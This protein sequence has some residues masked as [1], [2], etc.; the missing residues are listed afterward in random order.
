MNLE[1]V[2]QKIKRLLALL[3]A[4]LLFFNL[5]IRDTAVVFAVN[6]SRK[7]DRAVYEQSDSLSYLGQTLDG[8]VYAGIVSVTSKDGQISESEKGE[9]TD[10]L[11]YTKNSVI[12]EY[13]YVLDKEKNVKKA[14][15][16]PLVFDDSV[17][18]LTITEPVD[19]EQWTTEKMIVAEAADTNLYGIYY[20]ENE[21]VMLSEMLTAIPKELK[22]L[23]GNTLYIKE[24]LSEEKVYYFYAVDKAGHVSE[25]KKAAVKKVDCQKPKIEIQSIQ[26][27]GYDK[28]RGIYWKSNEP[29][30]LSFAVTDH[31]SG[32]K[33]IKI[34][35]QE[36]TEGISENRQRADVVYEITSAGSYQ[37]TVED[38]AGN[39]VSGEVINV[40]QDTQAP[41]KIAY[42]RFI[43]D[44]KGANAEFQEEKEGSWIS[45]IFKM[46]EN[47][48][49]KIWGKR[50]VGFEVYVYDAISEI[51]SVQMSYEGIGDAKTEE[52]KKIA[53][54][55]GG[56]KKRIDGVDY[57]IF[58]GS[59]P[60]SAYETLVMKKISIDSL[61]DAA[62]NETKNIVLE[63]TE[64]NALIY[65]DSV[66]PEIVSV[67][68]QTEDGTACEEVFDEEYYDNEKRY[69]VVTLAERFFGEE[70]IPVYPKLIVNQKIS[71]EKDRTSPWE[72]AAALS[73]AVWTKAEGVEDQWFAKAELPA[74]KDTEIEYQLVIDGYQDGAGN[75]LNSRNTDENGNFTSKLLVI[76]TLAP[77]IT[78]YTEERTTECTIDGTEVLR[79]DTGTENLKVCFTLD[80]NEAYYEKSKENLTITLYRD[81]ETDPVA[82][83]KADDLNPETNGR[84]HSYSFVYDGENNTE[85]KFHAE[86]TYAD[87]AGNGLVCAENLGFMQSTEKTDTCIGKEF[88]ID[89][90]NPVLGVV[91]SEASNVV[92]SK[93]EKTKGNKEPVSGY[94]AYYN[95]DITVTLSLEEM[96]GHLGAEDGLEHF[97]FF[98]QKDGEALKE[99][100]KITWI[101]DGRK[102]TAEF[103]LE[104][105]ADH[106]NDGDYQFTVKYRD[107][108]GNLMNT[109]NVETSNEAVEKEKNSVYTSPKL[110]IDT[111]APEIT[112]SYENGDICQ[113]V[114]S[115]LG[116]FRDYLNRSCPNFVIKIKDRNIN[117]TE[118][119][120]KLENSVSVTDIHEIAIKNT[121]IK[122][123]INKI[124]EGIRCAKGNENP[125]TM[126]IVLSLATD[127]N[128]RIPVV[129]TDLAGNQAIVKGLTPEADYGTHYTEY[130]TKDSTAPKLKLSYSTDDKANYWEWGY[131][132]AKSKMT[133]TAKAE[134]E[135]S[136][137]EKI[138]FKVVD[139]NGKELVR[140][141]AFQEPTASGKYQVTI[142]L[143]TEDFKGSVYAETV[144]YAAN[145]E[146]EIRGYIVESTSKHSAT[147]KAEITTITR[148]SRTVNGVDFYN[149]DITFKILLQDTYSGIAKW[150]Y[151]GG[152]TLKYEKDYKASVGTDLNSKLT[153]KEKD[154][155][156]TVEETLRLD[157]AAN[158]EN[159]IFV[160][161]EYTDN[162]G[163]RLDVMREYNID[164]TKPVIT[165]DYDLN[166][167]ANGKYYKETRTA[168]VQIRERNFDPEDVEW[169]ITT[170]DGSLPEISGWSQSGSGDN[171]LNVCT[172]AF[173]SDSDYTFS[174]KFMD[175]AGNVAD[176]TR[177]DE[178]TIDQTEPKVTVTYDNNSCRNEYYYDAS[179]TATIDILEHNFD[180]SAIEILVTADDSTAEIPHIL[181]W[182][183]NGDHNITT[184]I[185]NYDAEYTFDI[186]GTDLAFNELADYMP[187]HFVVDQTA[188]ELEIFDIED[189]S[190]NNGEVRPGIRYHDTNYD[191]NGAVILMTGYNNGAV[192]INVTRKQETNGMELKLDDFAY[193]QEQDDLYTMKATV[194]DLAGNRSEETVMFSVNRFGSVYTYDEATAALVGENGKYYTKT[195]QALK[196][197]ETNVDTLEFKEITV[198]FN[199]KL[200]TLKE[201]QDYTV[202]ASG[203]EVTW[204]QYQYNIKADNFKEEGTYVVTIYS[205]DRAAN[206]SDNNTKGKKIAFV[207]D[208]TNPSILVSGIETN[209]QYKS[210]SQEMFIDIDD[211]VLAAKVSVIIDGAETIFDAAKIAELDGRICISV[212]AANHAQNIKIT[213]ADAAGNSSETEITNVRVNANV[214]M[215]FYLN[216]AVFYGTLCSGAVLTA[217]L[218]RFLSGKKK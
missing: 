149:E 29:I 132:F 145:T 135:I 199:G 202:K 90:V 121:K 77:K 57:Q 153:D 120:K 116:S 20:T 125:E 53:V 187:D 72:E 16:K 134:D 41:E 209:G 138:V 78:Q 85:N 73:T 119:K 61:R 203:T 36:I 47:H 34:N 15:L 214:F 65:L 194:Y 26:H 27:V 40:R 59:I 96:F 8:S 109:E 206:R 71:G 146:S 186:A 122:E 51:V 162:V 155:L 218:W 45:Q 39:K 58:Y 180:P 46:A 12:P 133:I 100:P 131:F 188:P 56:K 91:Y 208:K 103:T 126:K 49:K 13:V 178:F 172:V 197:T 3:L 185:F 156:Y 79:N 70:E 154:I 92:N 210:S 4:V 129:F 104:A 201:G 163:H 18:E 217:L 89:H 137:I 165:V 130:V 157:A 19:H 152:H 112:T 177:V 66:N 182:S 147:G 115:A 195:E 37:I 44:A 64:G 139:E 205:E 215:L 101:H 176:Y 198:N 94:T 106:S 107:C 212:D 93:G 69:A 63:N 31:L 167:P 110:V 102:H 23:E 211:N 22:E 159:K 128:Y 181:G 11:S 105:L 17:P 196:I 213:A 33:N 200:R 108:A 158:N 118:V 183:Q 151:L 28:E 74:E 32:I 113:T 38:E 171:T 10:S 52:I 83:W 117:G 87:Q 50:E 97:E 5:W 98:I 216:K 86:I 35:D 193:V 174:L 14:A 191:S 81:Q 144:D 164:I 166:N 175:M 111:I 82:V 190:A 136:G 192:E 179:R 160:A 99:L 124:K 141:K 75:V 168:T 169:I 21:E 207:V 140:T 170:T 25:T 123:S 42:I 76:D 184:I 84:E 54:H 9:F 148:P 88:I 30:K 173:T 127:G 24:N 2:C 62:G 1:I 143:D 68:I 150:Q 142:P 95:K 7:E 55:D 80:E 114:K 60:C 161:A 48:W 43:S 67:E 6:G 204:K 189:M